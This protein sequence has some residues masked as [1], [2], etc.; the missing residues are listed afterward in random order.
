MKL[1]TVLRHWLVGF[2]ATILI[3]TVAIAFLALG[4]ELIGAGEVLFG[5]AF[6]GVVLGGPVGLFVGL[7]YALA[8]YALARRRHVQD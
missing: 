3:A 8:R 1:T 2:L 6:F 4:D 5:S 7:V